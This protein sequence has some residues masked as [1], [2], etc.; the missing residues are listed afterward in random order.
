LNHH[1]GTWADVPVVEDENL[2]FVRITKQQKKNTDSRDFR[3]WRISFTLCGDGC[4]TG[5]PFELGG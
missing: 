1:E 4:P 2:R 5:G 3:I